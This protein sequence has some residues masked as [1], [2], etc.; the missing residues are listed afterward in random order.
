M[1]SFKD[2]ETFNDKET[3]SE[4]ESLTYEESILK[5]RGGENPTDPTALSRAILK[6][7]S[8]NSYVVVKSVGPRALNIT[9]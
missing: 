1:E 7:L 4:K 3:F 5:V 8:K 2:K 6:V 9:M